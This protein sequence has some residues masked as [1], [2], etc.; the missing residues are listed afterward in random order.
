MTVPADAAINVATGTASVGVQAQVVH[1]DVSVYQLTGDAPEDLYRAG[2]HYLDGGMPT[3]AREFIGAARAHGYVTSEVEFHWLLALLSGRTLR[4]LSAEDLASL[5]AAREQPPL[6]GGEEWATGLKVINC[7]LDSLDAAE[8]DLLLLL[9]KL[10]ELGKL[11]QGK[12]FRHLDMFSAALSRTR[13]GTARS[14]GPRP[15][16]WAAIART[17]SGYSSSRNRSGPG[18]GG[19]TRRPSPRLPVSG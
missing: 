17:V 2:V 16:R 18:F 8:A 9:R 19:P 11:Q 4:Q 7:L 5:T 3:K 6:H 1:G 13:S 12:I 10:D 15:S 14:A